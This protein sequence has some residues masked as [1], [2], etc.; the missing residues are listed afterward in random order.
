MSHA[1][2]KRLTRLLIAVGLCWLLAAFVYNLPYVQDRIGWRIS[3]LRAK[4]KYALSPPEDAVFTPDQTVAAIVRT[5]LAA[6]TPTTTLTPTST[7]TSTVTPTLPGTAG[8]PSP[9]ATDSLP[10][11][12]P[13]VNPTLNTPPGYPAP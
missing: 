8:T 11:Y 13:P 4:I 10:G 5:T 12:P 2:L 9:T 7:N 3:E 6:F 1:R